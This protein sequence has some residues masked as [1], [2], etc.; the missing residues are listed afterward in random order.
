[1]RDV[2]AWFSPTT[3]V[4]DSYRF[5]NAYNSKPPGR[6]SRWLW[7]VCEKKSTV[8]VDK[9]DARGAAHTLVTDVIYPIPQSLPVHFFGSRPQPPTSRGAAHTLVTDV[10]YIWRVALISGLWLICKCTLFWFYAHIHWLVHFTVSAQ[11]EREKDR[12]GERHTHTH[13]YSCA[14]A[15]TH[16]H[17]NTRTHAHA[18]T[19][20][21][22]LAPRP[23]AFASYVC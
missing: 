20:T 16:T 15:H 3:V 12:E 22:R 9:S 8:R 6:Q 13:A 19:H 14:R 5:C 18:H 4:R 23:L 11:R 17:T 7:G 21:P 10:I 1:M 2:T